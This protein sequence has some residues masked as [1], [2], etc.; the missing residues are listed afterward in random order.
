[1][2]LIR[3][4]CRLPFVWALQ[5]ANEALLNVLFNLI[6]IEALDGRLGKC[7]CSHFTEEKI[8]VPKG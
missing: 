4:N 3:V 1:M 6:S 5:F 7:H 2:P 8:E